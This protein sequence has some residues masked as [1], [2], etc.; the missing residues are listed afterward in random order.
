MADA[1]AGQYNLADTVKQASRRARIYR[2][3]DD[4]ASDLARRKRSLKESIASR[5][6]IIFRIEQRQAGATGL[7]PRPGDEA[8]RFIAAHSEAI[9]DLK[10]Q[11]AAAGP[12]TAILAPMARRVARED[13]RRDRKTRATE[14]KS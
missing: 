11:L 10:E 9:R 8:E 14:R 4:G 12:A 6:M 13:R 5:K 1:A 7:P 3:E 2:L